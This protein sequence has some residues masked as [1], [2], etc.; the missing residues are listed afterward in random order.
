MGLGDCVSCTLCVQACPTGIDIRDGLQYECIG[1]AACIDACD[2]VMERIG[3]DK[4]LIRYTTE[5][6]L[7]GN[8]TRVLR[9]RV[10]VYGMIL[11][12]IMA[13]FVYGIAV[14]M[15]LGLDVIRDRNTLYRE[16]EDGLVENVYQ[17]KILNKDHQAHIYQ[18]ET[19]DFP[20]GELLLDNPKISV[21]AGEI[22]EYSVRVRVD[23]YSLEKQS[24]NFSFRLTSTEDSA[25]TVS[26]PARFVGP[27]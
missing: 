2:E 19:L 26:E 20:E 17:L 22:G 16:T 23:P 14:R 10:I 12:A 5:N 6:A 11:L 15:P 8:P 3:Y 27:G 1:C 13:A 9:P 24:T 18:L 7:V 21:K 4:G 25:I